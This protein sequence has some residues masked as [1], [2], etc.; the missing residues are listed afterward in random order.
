VDKG[1]LHRNAFFRGHRPAH[2][3]VLDH[4]RFKG[5]IVGARCTVGKLLLS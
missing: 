2:A 1:D 5:F 4:P 3:V